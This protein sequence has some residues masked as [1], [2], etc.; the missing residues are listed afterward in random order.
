[1]ISLFSSSR[2]KQ[3]IAHR[4]KKINRPGTK[5]LKAFCLFSKISDFYSTEYYWCDVDVCCWAGAT[6]CRWGMQAG[7]R[8]GSAQGPS[9]VDGAASSRPGEPA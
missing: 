6:K 9:A 2:K 8:E 5:A 3:Q 4:E 1:M 7:G